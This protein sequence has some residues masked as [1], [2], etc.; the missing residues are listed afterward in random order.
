MHSGCEAAWKE[1]AGRKMCPECHNDWKSVS[2]R[3]RRK[4]EKGVGREEEN[5]ELASPERGPETDGTT[6]PPSTRGVK[7]HVK[8][9]AEEDADDEDDDEEV[10]TPKQ[11]KSR[12]TPTKRK[13]TVRDDDVDDEE[14]ETTPTQQRGK[15]VAKRGESAVSDDDE[16]G[17]DMYDDEEA[18]EEDLQPT[19]RRKR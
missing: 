11:Q 3:R 18:D 2:E 4:I 5:V 6:A 8:R 16:I 17:A 14:G 10:P 19:R 13:N 7:S 15:L 1:Q 9:R 12:R